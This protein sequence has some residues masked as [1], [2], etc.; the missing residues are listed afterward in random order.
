MTAY[1][2]ID[3]GELDRLVN[4][5]HYSPHSILGAHP[6]DGIVTIRTVQHGADEVA[7]VIDG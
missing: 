4:G 7:V 3:L 5:A 2:R 1:A 6:A